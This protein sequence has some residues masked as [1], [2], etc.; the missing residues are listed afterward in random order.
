MGRSDLSQKHDGD[1]RAEENVRETEQ[2]E[3]GVRERVGVPS[4]LVIYSPR[5]P[6]YPSRGITQG[7]AYRAPGVSFR[8]GRPAISRRIANAN[9]VN[10]FD[11]PYYL[12]S[13]SRETSKR[14]DES[15]KE[16]TY[17]A[18]LFQWDKC[19]VAMIYVPH[20]L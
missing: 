18:V 8:A 10:V 16:Y 15:Q 13:C 2:G 3:T 5:A 7:W 12:S 20:V 4:Y 14:L 11:F 19:H 17:S 9:L 1:G 6:G